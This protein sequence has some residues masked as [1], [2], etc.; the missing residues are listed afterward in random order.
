[1]C[2][3]A[4]IFLGFCVL[5]GY[6]VARAQK[7]A[8]QLSRNDAPRVVADNSAKFLISKRHVFSELQ[9]ANVPQIFHFDTKLDFW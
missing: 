1:M 4:L 5:Q 6:D 8:F 3:V 2:H 7:V 9:I